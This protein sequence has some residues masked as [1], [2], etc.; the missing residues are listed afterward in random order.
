MA[1]NIFPLN[2][3]VSIENRELFMN[4]K[5]LV[6]WLTGLSGS[7][8]TTIGL[9]LEKKLIENGFAAFLLDGDSLRNGL[10]K[11]LGF[12]I[13]DRDENIRRAG[14]V[15]KLLSTAGLIVITSFI[16]PLRAQRDSIRKKFQKG[17]FVEV[18]VNASL[19]SC[20]IRDVKGLY[21]KARA[22]EIKDF[23][24]IDSPYEIPLLPE[25]IVETDSTSES[26]SLDKLYSFIQKLIKL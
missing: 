20:E 24:G 26:E 12:S 9:A 6:I 16:S 13:E 23:T 21:K 3:L 8:K 19:E 11:D 17:E 22:G 2:S 14:E 25:I 1:K 18:F 5:S 15:S 10:N 4:Q 7:G